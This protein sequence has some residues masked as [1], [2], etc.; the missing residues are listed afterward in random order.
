MPGFSLYIYMR[1]RECMVDAIDY[2]N[3]CFY[4]SYSDPDL[5]NIKKILNITEQSTY[6]FY[7][8]SRSQ[9]TIQSVYGWKL[10]NN[11]FTSVNFTEIV[12]LN[13]L[14]LVLFFLSIFV[15]SAHFIRISNFICFFLFC[16]FF[17]LIFF[18]L[19]FLFYLFTID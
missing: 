15:I 9:T 17:I 7:S 18:S 16:N 11:S 1:A 6:L 10:W 12:E 2:R 8:I 4:I 13:F 14:F 5:R 19:I 3:F